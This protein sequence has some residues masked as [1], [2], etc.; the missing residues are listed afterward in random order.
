MDTITATTAELNTVEDKL[1]EMG[2][3]NEKKDHID[4]QIN[5]IDRMHETLNSMT[6]IVFHSL[7][8]QYVFEVP[9]TMIHDLSDS[10]KMFYT[11]RRAEVIEEAD[12]LIHSFK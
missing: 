4:A 5:K 11:N 6:Q 12:K 9:A 8:H 7:S 1:I 10:L 3:L 2:R